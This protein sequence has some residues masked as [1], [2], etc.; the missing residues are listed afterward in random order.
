[1]M[2]RPLRSRDRGSLSLELAVFAPALLLII[3]LLAAGGRVAMAQGSVEQAAYEAA[4]AA[5]IARTPAQANSDGY[6][7]ATR[8]LN[9][10]GLECTSTTVTVS[11]GAFFVPAGQH[12]EV[13]ATVVCP[14]RF[15]DLVLPGLPSTTVARATAVSP[16]DTYRERE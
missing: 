7:A 13:S 2:W 12:A 14:I 16:L 4:R 3:G 1:M 10:Q 15:S 6:A 5:S 11:T 9:Q 8:S